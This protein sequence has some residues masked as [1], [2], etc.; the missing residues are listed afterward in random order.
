MRQR[1]RN[2]LWLITKPLKSIMFWLIASDKAWRD[3]PRAAF[4][5]ILFTSAATW[6]AA[7]FGDPY[8]DLWQL[9]AAFTVVFLFLLILPTSDAEEVE[10]TYD[11]WHGYEGIFQV[12]STRHGPEVWF[13]N[14]INPVHTIIVPLWRTEV[15]EFDE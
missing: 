4:W 15:K 2:A 10:E 9:G 13:D 14:P 12:R 5:R 6:A 11:E 1:I 3:K 8:A 7:H